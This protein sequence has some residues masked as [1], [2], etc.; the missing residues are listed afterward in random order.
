[1]GVF[2]FGISIFVLEI[3]TFLY[4]ANEESG[5]LLDPPIMAAGKLCKHL[6][7]TLTI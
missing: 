1:M 5:D 7:L 3:F 4:Y 2:V 6:E